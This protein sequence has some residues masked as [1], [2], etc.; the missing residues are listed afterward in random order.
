MIVEQLRSSHVKNSVIVHINELLDEQN[1]QNIESIVEEVSGVSNAHFNETRHH[2]M[3]VD[4]DPRRANSGTI[5]IRVKQQH[6]H[7]Q[8]I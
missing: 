6:L 1:R 5:L 8:L 7:A 2:L 3:V 4:Y